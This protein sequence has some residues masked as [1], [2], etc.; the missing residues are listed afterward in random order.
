MGFQ[1]ATLQFSRN[2]DAAVAEWRQDLAIDDVISVSLTD[3][4]GANSYIWRLVG[5]PE[6]SAAG[7]PGPEPRY[8]GTAQVAS[9]TVDVVGTY[10]VQC[11]VNGGAPDA[12]AIGGGVAI[13]E[14]FLAPGNRPLRLLGPGE[15]DEDVYDPMVA[16]GWIKMLNRW[17]TKIRSGGGTTD[18]FKVMSDEY[19]D[20]PDYLFGKV[21]STDG[22]VIITDDVSGKRVNFAVPSRPIPALTNRYYFT[23]DHSNLTDGIAVH[24]QFSLTNP[25]T[26]AGAYDFAPSSVTGTNWGVANTDSPAGT[27]G[28][29]NW[30]GG[31]VNVVIRARVRNAQ[32]GNTYYLNFGTGEGQLVLARY[33]VGDDH[34]PFGYQTE[35]LP[36]E[37]DFP[38]T[39]TYV[40]YYVAIAVQSLPEYWRITGMNALDRLRW[41]MTPLKV[42][43]HAIASEVF[44]IRCGGDDAS[45]IDTLFA[46]SGNPTGASDHKVSVDAGDIADYL[47]A[48]LSAGAN[49]TITKAGSEPHETV[50]I[51]ATGGGGGGSNSVESTD[52]SITVTSAGGGVQNIELPV[53][54]AIPTIDGGAGSAGASG[55][56][57]NEG[58]QHP[59]QP[60]VSLTKRYY[61]TGQG[62]DLPRADPGDPQTG[63]LLS[64][65]NPYDEAHALDVGHPGTSPVY[66]W[67]DSPPGEPG[68]TSWPSGTVLANLRVR[69]RNTHGGLTY[70]LYSGSGIVYEAMLYDVTGGYIYQMAPYPTA[71]VLSSSY[72]TFQLPLYV[73]G[74][75]GSSARRLR[76][77]LILVVTGGSLTDE[78]FEVRCGGDNASWF[79]TL[80]TPSS[81]GPT[82]HNDLT[83]RGTFL[84]PANAPLLAH[85]M[86]DI[87][88]GWVQTPTTAVAVVGGLLA[89]ASAS[90]PVKSNTVD[91]SGAGP[92]VGIELTGKNIGDSLE[93]YF[94]NTMTITNQGSPGNGSYG[95]VA[96]GTLGQSYPSPD[97]T[98]NQ[99]GV[100]RLRQ[101][102]G[103]WRPAGPWFSPETT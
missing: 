43:P 68:L 100:L 53:S 39:S 2:G 60:V 40:T 36:G 24:S 97:V 5:R 54:T 12:L 21:E 56:K 69:V 25:T 72:Q 77:D 75:S 44:E 37:F 38:I 13:L 87:E 27:P 85:P 49:V 59:A 50:Q 61:L 34:G 62:S 79:D 96:F 55:P 92:L 95:A 67:F 99:Y 101:C 63:Y 16:Q 57:S 47:F 32:S 91:V 70:T 94:S 82:V 8:L 52:G 23:H 7:G 51:A 30:S 11:I 46:P 48:K 42:G 64:T 17:L 103:I 93:L 1:S 58:H 10:I 65:T 18:T 26:E 74:L 66:I 33:C 88:P 3:N 89:L 31:I 15:S 6:G 41:A 81:G 28:I 86:S 98:I 78:V 83:G 14:S 45:Y 80:F 22:S 19:D 71:P 76:A 9:F 84:T 73:T 35:P 29:L 4:V 90:P 102:G 20:S